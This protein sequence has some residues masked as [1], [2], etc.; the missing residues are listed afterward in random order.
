MMKKLMTFVRKHGA[1]ALVNSF[2][3]ALAI[4][5]VN[6]ACAWIYHQPEVPEDLKKMRKF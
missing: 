2:A 4:Q 6:T 1:M 3:L 5:T